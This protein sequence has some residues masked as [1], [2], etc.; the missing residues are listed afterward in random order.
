MTTGKEDNDNGAAYTEGGVVIATDV[1]ATGVQ[2]PSS[3]S[4]V[5]L[6]T[7]TKKPPVNVDVSG[8]KQGHLFCGCCCDVRRATIAINIVS[9]VFAVISILILIA[10]VRT[11]KIVYNDDVTQAAYGNSVSDLNSVLTASIILTLLTIIFNSA[12]IVG[13]VRFNI[14]LV[15]SNV[16]WLILGCITS[17]AI[18]IRASASVAAYNFNAFNVLINL[19]FTC[20]FLYPHIMLIYEIKFTETMSKETYPGRELHSCCCVSTFH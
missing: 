15:L 19:A 12:A 6:S 18:N 8:P 14:W 2:E 9:L 3:N 1:E 13:A 5:G 7:E 16:I 10:A 20:F 17:L 4:N 11:A